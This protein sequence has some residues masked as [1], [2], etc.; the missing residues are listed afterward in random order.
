M[1]FNDKR[2]FFTPNVIS[3]VINQGEEK[4]IIKK[5]KIVR[6]KQ[7]LFIWSIDIEFTL[8]NIQFL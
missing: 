1:I 6:S 2:N 3:L 7:L 8:K 5:A 4:K